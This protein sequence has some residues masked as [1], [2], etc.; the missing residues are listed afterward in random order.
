MP[1]RDVY[2]G[3]V[4]YVFHHF[5]ERLGNIVDEKEEVRALN[6]NQQQLKEKISPYFQPLKNIDVYKFEKKD[7]NGRSKYECI[8]NFVEIEDESPFFNI[9]FKNKNKDN[10]ITKI[11]SE[12]IEDIVELLILKGDDEE[13]YARQ[14]EKFVTGRGFNRLP[15]PQSSSTT[16]TYV[17]PYWRAGKRKTNRKLKNKRK[18]GKTIKKRR[19]H[20]RK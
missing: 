5:G 10:I 8:G 18:K 3:H 7:T 1:P 2:S 14:L 11:S 16:T 4:T 17:D 20:G 13:E 9:V 15:P 19:K 6:S 12:N